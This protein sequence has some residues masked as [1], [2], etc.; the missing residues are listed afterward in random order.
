MSL[1]HWIL[2]LSLP[3]WLVACG[4]D[5][6]K[7]EPAPPPPPPTRV[8][9]SIKAE[10]DINP[11][12]GRRPSPLLLRVYELKDAGN[13]SAADFF[14]LYNKERETLGGDLVKRQEFTLVPDTGK[15]LAFEADAA[16]KYLAVFAAFHNLETARWRVSTEVPLHRTTV[17]SIQASTNQLSLSA[18][19][20]A[21]GD[22]EKP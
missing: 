1:P 7:N 10:P 16:T 8:E 21:P 15:S 9:L 13:F 12:A 17:I 11:D 14:A 19:P 6:V 20:K 18:S 2:V 4:S 22:A 5:E 3:F